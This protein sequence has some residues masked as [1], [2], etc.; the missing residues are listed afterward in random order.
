MVSSF[1]RLSL[2]PFRKNN[3][4]QHNDTINNKSYNK[5]HYSEACLWRCENQHSHRIHVIHGPLAKILTEYPNDYCLTYLG[6]EQASLPF[7][8]VL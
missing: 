2:N 6:D 4:A 5:N 1:H 8:K 7:K 3:P